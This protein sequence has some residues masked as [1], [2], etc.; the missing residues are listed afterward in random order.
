MAAYRSLVNHVFLPSV[1]PQSDAGDAFDILVQTTFKAL[2]EYKRLRPDQHSSVENA[3]RMTGNM[4]TAH[5]DSYIDEEKLARLMEAIPRDGGSI[6]LHVSAQ[7]AGMIISRVSPLETGFAIRFEAFE[8]APLNQAFYQSKGR[9]GRSFPGS[10]VD[11]DFPTFAEPGLVDTTAR[12]LVKMS[13]QAA[14]GMQPQVRKAKA[15]V[16]E[17]RDTT[18]PGMISEFIMGFLNA[19]GQSAHVDTISKN[20]REEVLLL[21]ARSPWRRSPV[22]LLLRS[23]SRSDRAFSA[24]VG[25]PLP[26]AADAITAEFAT[27]QTPR[28]TKANESTYTFRGMRRVPK[29]Q[30]L[31]RG[32]FPRA[33]PE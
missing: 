3:I 2:I 7:N 6:V 14:P 8:L 4:A 19:V 32:A 1:L 21:D 20:T 12:T 33:I 27:I 25:L 16:D 18:H 15:M 31:E 13:F 30:Q 26:L 10:A 24:C 29:E 9:L 23:I 22:W 5:V 28:Y 11:I 17:D